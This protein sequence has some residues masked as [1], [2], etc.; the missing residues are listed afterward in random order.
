M[1]LYNDFILNNL[2]QVKY[3]TKEEIEKEHWHI[4]GILKQKSNQVYKFDIISMHKIE[5]N[6]KGKIGKFE[7]KAD[8]IVYEGNNQWVIIDMLELQEYIKKNKIKTIHL[9]SLIKNLE[10]NIFINK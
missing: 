2:E 6:L 8:K 9:E 1:S 10:W 4:S 3:A 5:N 7:S